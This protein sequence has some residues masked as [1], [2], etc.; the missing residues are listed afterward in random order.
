MELYHNGKPIFNTVPSLPIRE[1]TQEQF[2]TAS[3]DEKQGIVITNRHVGISFDYCEEYD[4]EIDECKWHVRKWSNGYCELMGEKEYT[5]LIVETQ[6]GSLYQMYE[7]IKGVTFPVSLI[8][9]CTLQETV[10]GDYGVLPLFYTV[11]SL[12][13][14]S[15]FNLVR[16]TGVSS[17]TVILHIYLTGRWK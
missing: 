9:K 17:V 12:N 2:D 10:T 15:D 3:E 13:R 14:S 5:N 4:T 11:D 1:M 7:R 8:Q 16:S 6:Y